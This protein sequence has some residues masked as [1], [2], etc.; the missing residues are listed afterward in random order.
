MQLQGQSA[1]WPSDCGC[2]LSPS[3]D[4]HWAATDL[5]AALQVAVLALRARMLPSDGAP[6]DYFRQNPMGREIAAALHKADL[7]LLE[8][9]VA[10]NGPRNGA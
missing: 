5:A 2:E 10:L 3:C 9:P 8:M 1:S 4:M 6:E 7:L